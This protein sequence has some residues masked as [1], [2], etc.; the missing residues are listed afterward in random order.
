M[1][2]S[3]LGSSL[4]PTTPHGQEHESYLRVDATLKQGSGFCI[5]CWLLIRYRLQGAVGAA[6]I[7]PSEETPVGNNKS[8]EKEAAVSP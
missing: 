2:R 3:Q 6:R 7:L 8:P 1:I 4:S 5:P